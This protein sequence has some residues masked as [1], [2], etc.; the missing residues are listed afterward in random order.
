MYCTGE[1][2]LYVSFFCIPWTANATG[3]INLQVVSDDNNDNLEEGF[4]ATYVM[5][6]C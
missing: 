5:M 1:N 4:A 6:P 2:V 3:P